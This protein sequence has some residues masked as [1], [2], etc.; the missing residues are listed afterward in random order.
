MSENQSENDSN[1]AKGTKDTPVEVA[2]DPGKRKPTLIL[3]ND[4]APGIIEVPPKPWWKNLTVEWFLF[5]FMFGSTLSMTTDSNLFMERACLVNF[6][7][8]QEVC[9]NLTN[10]QDV[11]NQVQA[12]TTRINQY[13]TLLQMLPGGIFALFVGSFS[14]KYGRKPPVILSVLGTLAKDIL[15]LL[16]VYF[17]SLPVE[18]V[19]VSAIP[20]SLSG[21]IITVLGTVYSM[22]SDK[23][24]KSGRTI[25]YA[26]M[27]G[28]LFSAIP[29]ATLM[30]GQIYKYYSY[31]PVYGCSLIVH[32]LALAFVA[33]FISDN[34]EG[35]AK[36]SICRKMADF[37][38][39]D[40]VKENFTTCMK[41]RPNYGRAKILLLIPSG[42]IMLLSYI[43]LMSMIYLFTKKVYGW[44][45]PYY[46]T[47][48]TGFSISSMV[49]MIIAVPILTK[50]FKTTDAVLG[51]MG[52]ISLMAQTLTRAFA[53]RPW[54]FFVSSAVGFLNGACPMAFRSKLSKTVEPDEIGKIFYVLAVF[55]S[56]T[57]TPGSLLFTFVYNETL[58]TFPGA[59]FLVAGLIMIFPLSVF[60][61]LIWLESGTTKLSYEG[62]ENED[63]I[64]STSI[65]AKA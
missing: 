56:L 34:R 65:E 24:K 7:Y 47:V 26:L 64:P 57:P 14:D 45:L 52:V 44:D 42:C 31:I 9:A 20:V 40:S 62:V 1:V 4:P 10:H 51:L 32:V 36:G 58:D 46:T 17:D 28:F 50:V 21:G 29:L 33:Y 11:L 16:F 35:L 18:Y 55:E 49:I 37:F 27:E 25:K 30:A 59:V 23:T 6:N 60:L 48:S 61:W 13:N 63:E 43:S 41:K 39:L 22:A 54:L 15:Q 12:T 38:S 53:Y 19:L 3:V 8:S 2:N 5:L